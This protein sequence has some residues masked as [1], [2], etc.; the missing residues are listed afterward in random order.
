M[1]LFRVKEKLKR[2]SDVAM[3]IIATHDFGRWSKAVCHWT[4]ACEEN[5]RLANEFCRLHVRVPSKQIKSWQLLAGLSC[6]WRIARFAD[7]TSTSINYTY[8][9]SRLLL[10]TVLCNS[11]YLITTTRFQKKKKKKKFEIDMCSRLRVKL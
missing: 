1:I 11:A 9:L 10:R 2:D 8:Y 4:K 5:P 3:E 7:S 6:A